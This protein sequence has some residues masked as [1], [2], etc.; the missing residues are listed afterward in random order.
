MS[1]VQ[2]LITVGKKRSP[3][4]DTKSIYL[5]GSSGTQPE[6]GKEALGISTRVITRCLI[7]RREY[8]DGNK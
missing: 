6:D 3:K 8:I 1:G 5:A 7:R 2:D 4:L